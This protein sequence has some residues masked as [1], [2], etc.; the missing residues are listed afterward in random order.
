MARDKWEL[1]EDYRSVKRAIEVFKDPE[2]L[3]E[4]QDHIKEK[5]QHKEAM[6]QVADGNLK[7]ALG[8]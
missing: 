1:D 4:L 6:D 8:L 3:A 5:K 7:E 2:R